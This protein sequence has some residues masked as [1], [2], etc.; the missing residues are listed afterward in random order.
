[1]KQQ[2]KK[3]VEWNEWKKKVHEI[4][5]S[6]MLVRPDFIAYFRD[7]LDKDGN[8]IKSRETFKEEYDRYSKDSEF[9]KLCKAGKEE[10]NENI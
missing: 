3:D 10:T 2:I 5:Y 4:N 6:S 1:M 9:R 8:I 7:Y